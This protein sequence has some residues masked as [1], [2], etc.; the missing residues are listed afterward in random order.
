[1]TNDSLEHASLSSV[2]RNQDVFV[3]KWQEKVT[4]IGIDEY[5]FLRV[6][7]SSTGEVLT[8]HTDAHSF[9]VRHGI[10]R[11]KAL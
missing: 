5:G 3:D 4:I 8:L 9:D 1:M 10:I 2:D 11:E 7:K 6:R